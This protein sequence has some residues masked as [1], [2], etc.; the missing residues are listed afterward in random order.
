MRIL[1][2]QIR[3]PMKGDKFFIEQGNESEIAWVNKGL[4]EFGSYAD[5]YQTGALDLI[6]LAL[7]DR[8]SR[9]YNL[10]PIVFLIRH[11]IELRLK[12][13]I[14][15]LNFCKDQS[16]A[17]PVHHNIHTLW[18]EFKVAYLSLGEKPYGD[19]F[20]VIDELI[21]EMWIVD[22]NSMA[23]RYPV[24]KQGN[25]IQKLEYVNLANLKETFIRLC[26]VFDGVAMQISHYVEITEEML[27]DFYSS[28]YQ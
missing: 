25:K 7:N 2:E 15:G 6:N 12:E 4:Q 9:N 8:T 20:E 18:G 11:Y 23:F 19:T 3:Y 27:Q 13:L 14:Y 21:K 24:D 16:S 26:F 22:P 17:F 28:Y 5:S 1:D 10:Y